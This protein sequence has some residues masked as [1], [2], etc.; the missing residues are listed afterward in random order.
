MKIELTKFGERHFNKSFNGTK[1]LDVPKEEFMEKVNNLYN[2]MPLSHNKSGHILGNRVNTNKIRPGY[3]DFCK[4]FFVENFTETKT[5]TLPIVLENYSYL[6][7]GYS[8]RRKEELAVL[9]RW[10]EIPSQFVPKA[11]YLNLVLYTREQLYDEWLCNPNKQKAE[12]EL[13]EDTD[14]GIV[15]ILAQMTNLEEPMTPITMM[16]NALGK[17]HGGSGVKIDIEAYEKS[18]E[19]WWKNAIVK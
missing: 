18:V 14:Y 17:E 3:A 10:L 12:F 16:R 5:G 7:S 19:F 11:K 15:A 9:S 2:D 8:S 4:L 13:A 1:I 6:R